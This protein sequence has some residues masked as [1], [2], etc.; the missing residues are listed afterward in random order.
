VLS[1]TL[2]CLFPT[3]YLQRP[4]CP[5]QER[6][7][8]G[9]IPA[10]QGRAARWPHRLHPVDAIQ[11]TAHPWS[12]VHLQQLHLLF[13]QRGRC[14]LPNYTSEG[15]EHSPVKELRAFEC[16]GV[17]QAQGPGPCSWVPALQLVRERLAQPGTDHLNTWLDFPARGSQTLREAPLWLVCT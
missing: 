8:P 1:L 6:V 13:Q 11:Q 16:H 5:S 4:G 17:R 7:L 2:L 14:M 12:D 15:G 9:H 3:L 10:A